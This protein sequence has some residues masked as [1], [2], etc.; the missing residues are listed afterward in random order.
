[1]RRFASRFF[2]SFRVVLLSIGVVLAL[3]VVG[4]VIYR[5]VT[6]AQ[7]QLC[8]VSVLNST[9]NKLAFEKYQ[10]E[11]DNAI[12]I[13]TTDGGWGCRISGN[14]YSDSSP[15]WS[16]D[17]K[18]IA[19]VS[20]RYQAGGNLFDIFVMNSDGTNRRMVIGGDQGFYYRTPTWSPDSKSIAF[21]KI[22]DD[23]SSKIYIASTDGTNQLRLVTDSGFDGGSLTWS[24]DGKRIAFG[25]RKD[26]ST[27]WD[28]YVVN[29]DGSNEQRLTQNGG[30][31]PA[32]SPDGRQIVF[33]GSYK[34]SGLDLFIMDADGTK[35]HRLMIDVALSDRVIPAWSPDGRLIAF[36]DGGAIYV[37]NIDG[38]GLRLLTVR[39]DYHTDGSP[40][41]NGM[42]AS[43]K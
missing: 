10:P 41:W 14:N 19:F 36:V 21:S 5:L 35:L 11:T 13:M 27:L 42:V 20:L 33:A 6:Y 40:N 26:S 29:I 18:R 39:D 32:W 37:V 38:S 1:M 3:V 24:P 16:P 9:Q 2:R 4:V 15:A 22:A 7:S 43:Q 34:K 30:V 12:Y 17:G 23:K 8:I 25:M 28:I 31:D